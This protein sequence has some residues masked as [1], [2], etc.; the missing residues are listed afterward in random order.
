[1]VGNEPD[2]ALAGRAPFR[3]HAANLRQALIEPTN[4]AADLL[5]GIREQIGTRPQVCKLHGIESA[6]GSHRHT[7]TITDAIK[8]R[9]VD[10]QECSIHAWR[11]FLRFHDNRPTI[12]QGN[13][14]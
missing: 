8:T 9:G 7:V 11:S 1:M 14:N 10:W 2:P 12:R 3:S 4:R 5:D 6:C 13:L